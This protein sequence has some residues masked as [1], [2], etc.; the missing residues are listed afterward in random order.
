MFIYTE[1]YAESHRN[2]QTINLNHEAHQQTPNYIFDK[3]FVFENPYFQKLDVQEE[4]VSLC[5]FV[6]YY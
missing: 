4:N 1:L 5:L 2:T 6:S 3:T